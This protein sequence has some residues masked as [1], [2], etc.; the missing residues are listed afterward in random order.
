MKARMEPD[1][2]ARGLKLSHLRF[3]AALGEEGG[4]SAAAAVVGI[5]QPAAS[6]LAAEIEHLCGVPIYRRT[7]RGI[8]L[9]EAGARFAA[10]SA[11]ILRE[12]GEA[13]REVG[14]IGQGVSGQVAFGSVT[15]PAIDHAI[16]ALRRT[17]L[18]YPGISVRI[19]VAASDVLIPMLRSGQ[20][21]FAICRVPPGTDAGA[22]VQAPQAEEP[23]RFVARGGHPLCRDPGPVTDDALL[24]YD[25]VLP[26]LGTIL[27]STID[28]ALRRAHKPPPQH[29]LTTSSFLFT[30]A[31]LR[32]TNAVAPIATALANSFASADPADHDG[33]TVLKTDLLVT[34]EPFALVRRAGTSLTP[35]AA[36]VFAEVERAL[37]AG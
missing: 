19:D 18:S 24:R 16:P 9:T 14:E 1:L 15:G 29:V 27:R 11:R 3:A 26:P 31:Y 36:T 6:R 17:R 30:L 21:D 5:S 25:W 23:I 37:M 10:R 8:A 20:L 28:L 35:A 4:I 33:I 34:V 32:Q 22:F 12:I 13:G 7:G 2:L